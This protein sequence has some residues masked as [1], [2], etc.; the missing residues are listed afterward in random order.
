VKEDKRG[1]AERR[2][3]MSEE[4]GEK[5]ISD[6]NGEG[7]GKGREGVVESD[8]GRLR[9]GRMRGGRGRVETNGNKVE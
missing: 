4:E 3:K 1:K 7:E 2:V 5:E 9:G 6:R 8:L